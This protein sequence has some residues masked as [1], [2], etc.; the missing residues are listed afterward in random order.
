MVQSKQRIAKSS[1]DTQ[2]TERC[3]A[4]QGPTRAPVV[5]ALGASAAD[6]D[7]LEEIFTHLP[8]T[9]GLALVVVMHR[10]PGGPL[11]LTELIRHSTALPVVLITEGLPVCADT[12][13]VSPA[14]CALTLRGAV[15]HLTPW[16]RSDPVHRPIDLFFHS[17]A[18]EWGERAIGVILSGAGDDGCQGGRILL[19]HGGLVLAQDPASAHEKSMPERAI[20]AGVVSLVLSPR[21]IAAQLR[22]GGGDRGEDARL[23]TVESIDN[24]LLQQLFTL[25]KARTGIDFGAY[26]RGTIRR[27]VDRRMRMHR[28]ARFK[29]YLA[30]LEENSQEVENLHREL[31]IGVT[32]FFR[33]PE[34][35]ELLRSEVLPQLFAGGSGQG[36]VRIWHAC[37]ASGE[38]AY[39]V[40]MLIEEYLSEKNLARKVQIFATDLDEKA[41]NHARA[42]IYGPGIEREVGEA[43]LGRFFNRVDGSWQVSKPLREMIVFAQ[44]NILKDPSFSRLDLLVCRNFLIYLIPRMQKRLMQLFQQSL[45]PGGFLFLGSAETVGLQQSLFVPVDNKWKIYLRKNDDDG[46]DSGSRHALLPA[47]S[48][49]GLADRLLLERYTPARAIVDRAGEVLHFS[50]AAAIFLERQ[51]GAS[52]PRIRA[53]LR[54]ALELAVDNV[55]REGKE[56]RLADLT[57]LIEGGDLRLD[58]VAMPLGDAAEYG[59]LALVVFLVAQPEG[60]ALALRQKAAANGAVS[61]EQVHRLKDRLVGI[62]ER[63]D[64]CVEDLLFAD[65]DHVA[66]GEK[67]QVTNEELKAANEELMATNEELRALEEDLAN[68]NDELME[69][70]K[71][72]SQVNNDLENLFASSEIAIVFL[73]CSLC[74]KRFSPAMARM[75]GLRSADIGAPFAHLDKVVDW[76]GLSADIA[77]ML[78]TGTTLEREVVLAGEE[79]N[80]IMRVLPYRGER[81]LVEGVVITLVDITKRKRMEMTLKESEDTLRL[82]IEQA[83]AGLAM[84]DR[85]MRYL[86]VSRRWLKSYG[87]EDRDVIGVSHYEIFPEIPEAWKEAHRRGMRGEILRREADP[88]FR[89]DGSMQWIRWEIRPWQTATGQI[90]GIVLFSEDITSQKKAEEERLRYELLSEHSR[91]IIL[92]VEVENGRLA[93]ANGAACTAYGYSREELLTMTI[94][95]LRASNGQGLIRIQMERAEQQGILFETCHQRRDGTIFPVEVNSQGTEIGGK[96]MLLSVIRDISERKEAEEELLRAFDLQRLSMESAGLG[97]WEHDL[98]NE[99]FTWS[100]RSRR[101]FGLPLDTALAL[102]DILERIH[103]ADRENLNQIVQRAKG[104]V[105]RGRF[106]CEHRVV[107][108]DDSE[109]W[110]QSQGQVYFE[111]QEGSGRPVRFVGVSRDITEEKK[112]QETSARLAD[113]VHSSDDAINS[114]DLNGVIQSWN[115]AAERL[116]GYR[117]KE[118]V[119][120]TSACLLPV[121]LADEDG[122]IRKTI[123]GGQRIDHYETVRLAKDG[124]RVDVSLTVSPIVDSQGQT[125][126]VSTIARDITE[127][128]R[129]AKALMASEERLSLAMEA[130]SEALWDWDLVTGQIYRSPRYYSLVR[131][132]SVADNGDLSFCQEIVHPEDRDQVMAAIEAHIGGES[133]A[134]D[135]EYRLHPDLGAPRWLKVKGKVV[136][137]DARGEP[138]RIVGTLADVTRVREQAQALLVSEQRRKLALEAARA[139]TWEW[140]LTTGANFWSDEMWALFNLKPYSVAP[141]YDTWVETMY[142]EDREQTQEDLRQAVERQEPFQIEWRIQL[143]DDSVRW[144]MAQGRPAFDEGK[145]LTHYLG[146]TMDITERKEYEA[147]RKLL[148]NQLQQAQKLEA[149]GTLAGGIA[150]DFNNILAAIIGYTEMAKFN[151]TVRTELDRDLGKVMEAAGRATDLVRQILAFSRQQQAEQV[152]IEP[153][154]VVREAVK[155]LRPAL[156]STITIKPVNT[157]STLAILADPTRIHQVVMNLCTNA[158]HAMEA[159]GGTLE[160]TLEDCEL[161]ARDLL[162]ESKAKPG[163]FVCLSVADTGPGIAPEIINKIF[164]PYFTTKEIGRG[165]GL[166]LSIVHSI[167]VGAGGFVRC[168]S[169]LGQGATFHVYLPGTT[170]QGQPLAIEDGADVSGRERILLID[171]EK[172]LVEMEESLLER[173]G[174]QVTTRTSSVEALRLFKEDPQAFD[175]VITDQTMPGMTGVDLARK[176][177]ALR[178]D[179]PIILCT[180]FSNLVNEQQARLFGI[181][182]FAMK[183]LT[184]KN[185]AQLLREA[186]AEGKR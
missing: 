12:V 81:E 162:H 122:R 170:Q 23:A 1:S 140:D 163:R 123:I 134:I 133:D 161:T 124:R 90:G 63:L 25:L 184:S 98:V 125:I 173:L 76:P 42:G 48:L 166:G 111:E 27:R 10:P 150:H 132:G 4:E 50:Q 34:A 85:D 3:L 8:T 56:Q 171:D 93:E 129:A 61:E 130:T 83:P 75:F 115:L 158:F 151:S 84:F 97:A 28:L 49:E 108:A 13:Y 14:D 57:I 53:E 35:F 29:E 156:P 95:D 9:T 116:F 181:R 147:S 70:I 20:A 177:L 72:I 107:W 69:K 30:M 15:F 45:R 89:Q 67:L 113:L 102:E 58:L 101:L 137:R 182:G 80:F 46:A 79:R 65:D 96:R 66:T 100:D 126:G 41:I 92:F 59:E 54:S 143:A 71:E 152:A 121:E 94:H 40:A 73:D 18:V 165:T 88:F 149:I 167:A 37:C 183:P 99:T 135:L 114:K 119:G 141:S 176:M 39:S 131:Q 164:D 127:K 142:P 6:Y 68:V 118:M 2:A 91:D 159:K 138:E 172:I 21:Q 74:L 19:E 82:F 186:L 154:L 144:L 55:H 169:V 180:G 160:I 179:I 175:A 60:V 104:G 153:I 33:D 87:M 110:L 106:K 43:R 128:K 5:V 36:P 64:H 157:T 78:A 11:P 17:L 174:Y 155:L 7:P 44:H 47:A 120:N 145:S 32:G 86:Q 77:G 146:V 22:G 38:E 51:Q 185:L 52:P 105:D 26:K 136:S 168:E 109:H 112:A 16:E 178:P 103:E 24:A 117:A 139:A 148:E 31:L 62:S